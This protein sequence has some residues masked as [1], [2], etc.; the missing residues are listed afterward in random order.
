MSERLKVGQTINITAIE[1][2]AFNVALDAG[3]KAILEDRDKEFPDG[4]PDEWC[5]QEHA[6]WC[7]MNNDIDLLEALKK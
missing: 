5:Q 4:E 7:T 2:K 6:Q 3:I 1:N